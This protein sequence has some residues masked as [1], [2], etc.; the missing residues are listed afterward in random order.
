MVM[1][2]KQIENW[3]EGK[4]GG[5]AYNYILMKKDGLEDEK[6]S[7]LEW[8]IA[9]YLVKKKPIFRIKFLCSIFFFWRHEFSCKYEKLFKATD[10]LTFHLVCVGYHKVP[11]QSPLQCTPGATNSNAHK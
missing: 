7:P 5:T 4:L 10:Q 11:T 2:K 6:K 1:G 8:Q 3:W 9:H